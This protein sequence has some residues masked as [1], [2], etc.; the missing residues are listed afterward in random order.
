MRSHGGWETF[1]QTSSLATQVRIHT[2]KK[3]YSYKEC[4]KT[5]SQTPC[6]ATHMRTHTGEKPYSCK[7]CG[8]TFCRRDDLTR[9]IRVHGGEKPYNSKRVSFAGLLSS[10]QQGYAGEHNSFC[11]C[12]YYYVR[13]YGVILIHLGPVK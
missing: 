10:D 3:P 8:K 5:F 2:G 6:L 9:H 12:K 7:D 11:N 4:G 13:K 1:S